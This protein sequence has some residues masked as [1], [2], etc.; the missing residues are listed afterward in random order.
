MQDS[1]LSCSPLCTGTNG[2]VSGLRAEYADHAS[3]GS[4]ILLSSVPSPTPSPGS[5]PQTSESITEQDFYAELESS[6]PDSPAK[7]NLSQLLKNASSVSFELQDNIPGVSYS[8]ST[9]TQHH[10]TP[11]SEVGIPL[12]NMILFENMQ[13]SRSYR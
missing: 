13:G 9:S 3:A 7:N 5:T 4:T 2:G 8:T 12:M 11:V 6:E 10:W 1:Y